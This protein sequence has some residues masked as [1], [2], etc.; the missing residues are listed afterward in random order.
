[1]NSIANL[2]NIYL[3]NQKNSSVNEEIAKYLLRHLN[4]VPRLRVADIAEA[5]HVS[6]PSVL[7]FVRELGFESFPEFREAIPC[8]YRAMKE[9][10]ATQERYCLIGQKAGPESGSDRTFSGFRKDLNIY[11][12]QMADEKVLAG[13]RKMAEDMVRYHAITCI[14]MGLSCLFGD[15]LN[16][17]LDYGIVSCCSI[18]VPEPDRMIFSDQNRAMIVLV[19]RSGRIPLYSQGLLPYLRKQSS[20]IWL[21]T[22]SREKIEESLLDHVLYLPGSGSYQIDYLMT[23][24][25]AEQVAQYCELYQNGGGP[26]CSSGTV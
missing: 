11:L 21:V 2:L 1:M 15:Y 10:Y 25:V 3:K 20:C 24:I 7:R 23:Q 26:A 18:A 16:T 5:C 4:D 14:G 17:R 22:H 19:S 13:V 8:Q 12:A 9:S 6:Q